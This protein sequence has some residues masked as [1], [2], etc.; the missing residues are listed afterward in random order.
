VAKALLGAAAAQTMHAAV[1][2]VTVV[3]ESGGASAVLAWFAFANAVLAA[4]GALTLAVLERASPL[5]SI[6]QE[7]ARLRQKDVREGLLWGACGALGAALAFCLATSSQLVTNAVSF[8]SVILMIVLCITSLEYL[9]ALVC[10]LSYTVSASIV[11]ARARSDA[12]K[13]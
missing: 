5:V 8:E 9:L 4:G 1:W 10:R 6:K 2:L 11:D 13:V 12:A 3:H 7:D